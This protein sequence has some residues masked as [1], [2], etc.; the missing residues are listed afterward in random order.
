MNNH[1]NTPTPE[2]ITNRN[3]AKVARKLKINN[4]DVLLIKQGTSLANEEAITDI[5]HAAS[6]IGLEKCIII[7]VDDFDSLKAI[8]ETDMNK[9]GWFRINTL[10]KLIHKD[11]EPELEKGSNNHA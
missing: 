2:K 1:R 10:R 8:N 4:G 5:S 11:S 9:M 3:L 6:K 7:V